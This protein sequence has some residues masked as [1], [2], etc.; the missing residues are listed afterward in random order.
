MNRL[1]GGMITGDRLDDASRP[2]R[3]SCWW[4]GRKGSPM[5]FVTDYL[6]Q[7][8]VDFEVA[9]HPRAV[10][11]MEEARAL[12]I[13]ADEVVKTVALTTDQGPALLILPASRRLDMVLARDAV[14][15]PTARLA[16]EDELRQ[17]FAEC[18]LGALPPLGSLLGVAAFLD[19]EVL[20][21]DTV[22]FAAGTQTESVKAHPA[23]LF[24]DEPAKVTPLVDKSDR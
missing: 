9:G 22:M 4:R 6:S 7:R 24:R 17:A 2:Q 23:D 20:D 19:P 1:A 5:S 21:H 12:G 10:T 13:A 18:E 11:S 8:G 3:T 15:D 16:T 14:G